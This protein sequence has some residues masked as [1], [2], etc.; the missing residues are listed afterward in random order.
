MNK[1]VQ[2]SVLPDKPGHQWQ[3][4]IINMK[5]LEVKYQKDT[6]RYLLQIIDIYSRYII[7]EPLKSKTSKDAAIA[8]EKV[9]LNHV[10]PIIIQC[11]NVTEFKGPETK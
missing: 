2:K 8:L 10:S 1:P 9:K 7:P 6:Y 5:Y 11:D 4:D 3:I